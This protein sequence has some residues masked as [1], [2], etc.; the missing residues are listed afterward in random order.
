MKP[1]VAWRI[2]LA[3]GALVL[4]GCE[5]SRY[6][7]Q[8]I[9]GHGGILLKQSSIRDVLESPKTAPATKERLRQVLALRRFAEDSLGLPAGQ[10]YLNYAE[11][12]TPY[13]VWNVYASPEFSLEA[14]DWWYPV[15]GRLSYRGYFSERMARECAEKLE[16]R[17]L[18]VF[19]GGV[20]AYS[21]LGWFKDPVLNT[22]LD[23]DEVG[24]ADLIFHE[25]A[26][27]KLFVKGDTDFN[28][29][30]ATAVAREGVRRWLRSQGDEQ[31]AASYEVLVGRQDAF[32]NLVLQTR[33]RLE[34]LYERHEQEPGGEDSPDVWRRQKLDLLAKLRT[35]YEALKAGWNGGVH[36]DSWFDWPVNNARLNAESTYHEWVPGFENLLA[37][38]GGDLSEF[39]ARVEVAGKLPEEERERTLAEWR[40]GGPAGNWT[41]NTGRGVSPVR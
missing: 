32:L 40:R 26:H 2:F 17:G 33:R 7:G 4:A 16:A 5:T 34:S 30:F 10:H 24:L 41:K 18:D 1:R 39:Y 25:L 13:V 12:A 38:V 36:F 11:L 23:R 19:V 31:L 20:D 9:R 15:V 3:A 6:Y 35:D 21:T 37:R 29:A 27:Q 8:A 22:F 28:E 14:E